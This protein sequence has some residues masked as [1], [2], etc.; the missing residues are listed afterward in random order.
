MACKLIFILSNDRI[1]K[2]KVSTILSDKSKISIIP[3]Y[4]W[5]KKDIGELSEVIP[6]ILTKAYFHVPT[7]IPLPPKI[8][9]G[10]N[11]E[12]EVSGM[13][14]AGENAGVVG[15]YAAACM[16][17]IAADSACK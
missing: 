6:D 16:G 14:V 17:M 15:I 11:L 9:I 1:L 2:E 3:E 7:I 4:E 13:F 10:T 5:I 12:T 8:N